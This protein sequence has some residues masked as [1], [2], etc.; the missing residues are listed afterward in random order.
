MSI[1]KVEASPNPDS[2]HWNWQ[3]EDPVL[4]GDSNSLKIILYEN[5]VLELMEVSSDEEINLFRVWFMYELAHSD[6]EHEDENDI[7]LC[8]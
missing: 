1:K 3:K 7:Y 5:K 8:P 2:D 4:V 6:C